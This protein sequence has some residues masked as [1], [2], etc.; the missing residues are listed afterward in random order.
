M[1]H[2]DTWKAKMRGIPTNLIR[3]STAASLAFEDR[4]EHDM[5]PVASLSLPTDHAAGTN[6]YNLVREAVQPLGF[7]VDR[8]LR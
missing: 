7:Q 3:Q 6:Q 1:N 8:R 2:M 4:Q 5:T